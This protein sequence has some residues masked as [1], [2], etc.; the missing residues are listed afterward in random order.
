MY[1]CFQIKG[2]LNFLRNHL[3]DIKEQ[4]TIIHL[5]LSKNNESIGKTLSD[6]N[7]TIKSDCGK[8]LAHIVHIIVIAWA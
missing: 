8:T 1:S 5:E 6:I 7:S 3:Q 2:K 4:K